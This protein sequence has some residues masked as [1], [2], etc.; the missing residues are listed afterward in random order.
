[1]RGETLRPGGQIELE[2][3]LSNTGDRAGDEVVQFYVRV[4]GGTVQRPIRQLAGFERVHLR[5][6][7]S[8]LVRFTLPHTD[9]ALCYWDER[10]YRFVV[11]PGTVDLMIG[12]SSADIRLRSRVAL[13]A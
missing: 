7:A 11:E 5:A 1:M 8:R 6:G 3:R 9:P 2:M 12:S 13:K 10:R 4:A